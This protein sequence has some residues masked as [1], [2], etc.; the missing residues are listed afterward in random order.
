MRTI[1]VSNIF[2]NSCDVMRGTFTLEIAK[3]LTR[4]CSVDVVAP[5]PWVPSFM[6]RLFPGKYAHSEVP[7]VEE[8]AGLR[9]LHPRYLVI[10]KLFGSLHA[11]SLFFPLY[12]VTKGL[13]SEGRRDVVINAHWVY[14]EG[15]AAVLVAR[16]LGVPVILT[17]LGC[18]INLYAK[19]AWR[20]PQIAWAIRHSDKVTAVSADLGQAMVGLGSTPAQTL[21]IPNGI[22]LKK[23]YLMDR[24]RAREQLGLPRNAQII[25]TVG[26]QD[27]VKGTRYL[28]EAIGLLRKRPN[29]NME[30]KLLLIGDGPLQS[31]LQKLT[32]DVGIADITQFLGRRPHSEIALWT[33]AAD[34][35]CLPSLREGHPNVLMEAFACGTPVVA[36]SV[37]AIPEM[38]TPENGRLSQ[39]CDSQDLCDRIKE[40]LAARWS[41]ERIRQSV[42]GQGWES[43]ADRYYH[44]LASVAGKSVR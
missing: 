33:N 20:R 31:S 42:S 39:V 5:L 17:A 7:E 35:F 14:P 25:L 30:Q 15:V 32:E 34:V 9:V 23:F 41:R 2:P 10:P 3:A 37:G 6:R 27:E 8:I 40:V 36:S 29:Q 18:D 1:L 38:I 22:D 19:M 16:C 12:K 21:V 4:R 44:V 26:S 11:L 13:L 28:I 24:G 43:C